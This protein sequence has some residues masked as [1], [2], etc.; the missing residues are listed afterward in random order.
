MSVALTTT[1]ENRYFRRSIRPFFTQASLWMVVTW[2][3]PPGVEVAECSI[4]ERD[5]IKR[6]P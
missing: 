6:F 2:D 5:M 1:H 3:Y 4:C